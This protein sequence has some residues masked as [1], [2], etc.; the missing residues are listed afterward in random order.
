ML[1]LV[2][3]VAFCVVVSGAVSAK[4]AEYAVVVSKETLADAGWKQVVDTLVDK[5]NAE[6]VTF[7]GGLDEAKAK[8]QA[9]HPRFTCFVATPAEAT[10]EFVAAVHQL[11]REYD[12]DPYTD[13]RWGILTGYD[14]ANALAIAKTS[15]PLVIHK[16]AA[17]TEVALEMCE[18]GQCFDELVQGKLVVKDKGGEA[19]LTEGPADSTKA[20]VDTLNEY[21]PDL[22]VTSGHATERDWMIGFRY[23]NGF[24]KS[25]A[26]QMRGADTTG[27]VHQVDSPNVKVYLPIGNC[28]MG[29][30]DGPDAMALA[31]MNDAGVRQMIGYTV[32]TWFGYAGWGCLDYFVEQPG[33]Y[34]FTE[35]FLANHHALIHKLETSSED[36]RGL[37]YD[38]DTLAF[39]GDPAWEARMAEGDCAY[40]QELTV[41]KSDGGNTYTLTIT[42][43]HG[44]KSFE[45]VNMNGSQRGWRPM[46]AFLPERIGKATIVRGAELEPVITD[47]FVLVPNPKMVEEGKAYKVVFEAEKAE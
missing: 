21:Q 17:G 23:K 38:R 22:F 2:R 34:T 24:F 32:P 43:R 35:A 11:T 10:R 44:A 45:P 20:L 14:A 3:V 28:L 18:E 9:D 15:E 47:D 30:I 31:W 25:K 41:E 13:T 46:V 37:E 40:D 5:H 39:Y 36:R 33:R 8:L 4:S 16:V 42:P 29:N 6:I 7:D 12:D 27:G 26:G 1:Q 19:K